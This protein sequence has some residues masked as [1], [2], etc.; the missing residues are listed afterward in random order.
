METGDH[1]SAKETKTVEAPPS[2][3]LL[4][5]GA[6]VEELEFI[7]A[8]HKGELE[9]TRRL[10]AQ[11]KED[12]AGGGKD[13]LGLRLLAKAFRGRVLGWLERR[14]FPD[15]PEL[16]KEA[17]NDTLWRVWSRINSYDE[18]RSRILT[19][20]MNQARYAALDLIKSASRKHEIPYAGDE[21]AE[22]STRGESGESRPSDLLAKRLIE[23]ARRLDESGESEP[24][25][26]DE[27]RALRR[28]LRRLKKE[29]QRILY[30]HYVLGYRYV[31][32]AREN[33]VGRV[34]PEE[35][36][37]VYG[38]RAAKRLGRFYEEELAS[39]REREG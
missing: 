37:R 15:D 27:V 34:L 26:G 20:V 8:L 30:L 1:L 36:V 31:E 23:E 19:W 9:A 7:L 17:W 16:A 5:G 13:S 28:A 35:H 18:R 10:V 11:I 6:Y 38:N 29:E 32:I 25:T 2:R 39:Q 33:L 24:L 4:V 21:D 22:M 12:V 3:R 14:W